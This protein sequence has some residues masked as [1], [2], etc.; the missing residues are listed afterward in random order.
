MADMYPWCCP[1]KSGHAG[2]G[3]PGAG[4]L[5]SRTMDA[6]GGLG[7][8]RMGDVWDRTTEVLSGR[9]RTLAGIAAVAIF[10]PGLVRSAFTLYAGKDTPTAALIG[11][12]IAIIASL[13]AIWAQLTL[14]GLSTDPATTEPQAAA[15]AR[16]RLLP[17]VG[18]GILIGIAFGIIVIPLFVALIGAGWTADVMK[19]GVMP[20]LTPGVGAF[21]GVYGLAVF[22][23]FLWAAARLSLWTAVMVNERLGLGAIRRSF[24]LTHGIAWRIIGVLILYLI[25]LGVAFSAVTAVTGVVFGLILGAAAPATVA[26][27]VAVAGGLVSAA[28]STIAAVFTAQLYVATRAASAASAGASFDV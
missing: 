20:T 5:V 6:N 15:T 9:G 4:A 12:L 21:V 13:L 1:R 22:A 14:I 11:G 3:Q 28:F 18:V 8:V 26:F 10:L 2:D 23:L 7:M 25:V 24:E 27:L 17:T 19:T 16:A